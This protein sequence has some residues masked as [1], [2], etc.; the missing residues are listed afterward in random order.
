MPDIEL[1]LNDQQLVRRNKLADL[2]AAGIDPY[3]QR[4]ASARTHIRGGPTG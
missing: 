2:R 3:P 1:D 4:L